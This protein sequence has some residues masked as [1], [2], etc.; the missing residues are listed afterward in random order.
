MHAVLCLFRGDRSS[1]TATPQC[2]ET[3]HCRR[4]CNDSMID[5]H[6]SYLASFCLRID[7]MASVLSRPLKSSSLREVYVLAD[8]AAKALNF[9]PGIGLRIHM[10][11]CPS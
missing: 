6:C 7:L 10:P 8:G 4:G 9:P 11:C 3:R 1:V 2:D 5:R